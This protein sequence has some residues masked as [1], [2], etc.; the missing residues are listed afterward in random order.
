M[1]RSD[2]NEIVSDINTTKIIKNLEKKEEQKVQFSPSKV[3]NLSAKK[4]I[5]CMRKAKKSSSKNI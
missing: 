3:E 5:C 4:Q 1:T 2:E